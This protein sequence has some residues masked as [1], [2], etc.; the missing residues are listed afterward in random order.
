MT[1][2]NHQEPYSIAIIHHGQTCI[3]EQL[4]INLTINW[5]LLAV[6]THQLTLNSPPI[7]P[8]RYLQ[9]AELMAETH[10][11]WDESTSWD[12]DGPFITWCRIHFITRITCGNLWILGEG[13][14]GPTQRTY[15]MGNVYPLPLS[16]S[17][18]CLMP[19]SWLE[20]NCHWSTSCPEALEG[21]WLEMSY[22]C[23][24]VCTNTHINKYK[25]K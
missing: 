3:N 14:S 2:I 10:R 6:T 11:A 8:W 21:E 5:Q 20:T 15:P 24:C 19:G 25:Y 9:T 18:S 16:H 1:I 23:M 22:V 13:I 17:A 12:R 4:T 7:C